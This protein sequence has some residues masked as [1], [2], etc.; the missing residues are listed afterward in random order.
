MISLGF[1]IGKVV[2]T[3][4]KAVEAANALRCRASYTP[5][6]VQSTVLLWSIYSVCTIFDYCPFSFEFNSIALHVELEPI[7]LSIK[8]FVCVTSPLS[9]LLCCLGCA[10]TTCENWR[11]NSIP[12]TL[13]VLEISMQ[14]SFL[15]L[16]ESSAHHSLI[17][18]SLWSVR[19]VYASCLVLCCIHWLHVNQRMFCSL[20]FQL[21]D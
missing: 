14:T 3:D 11:W 21:M 10:H 7:F 12:L 15:R 13:M 20:L 8:T 4:P 19:R 1:S 2:L 6:S 17:N 16:L 18:Y 5:V 9:C